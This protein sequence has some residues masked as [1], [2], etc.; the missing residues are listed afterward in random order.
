VPLPPQS[1]AATAAEA[2]GRGGGAGAGEGAADD[3][4]AERKSG[5]SPGWGDT[6]RAVGAESVRPLSP[7]GMG[8]LCAE[9]IEPTRPDIWPRNTRRAECETGCSP[10]MVLEP[11]AVRA[12]SRIRG[13]C[14]RSEL[15]AT[16]AFISG[17]AHSINCAPADAIAAAADNASC[18]PTTRPRRERTASQL[19]VDLQIA[20]VGQCTRRVTARSPGPLHS[21][22]LS[23]LE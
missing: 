10:S 11:E 18:Q 15:A 14:E 6:G 20:A 5:V 22:C 3:E 4:S 9:A 16:G 7:G 8:L 2:S 19:R 17:S 23:M 21:L 12:G 1:A 13:T